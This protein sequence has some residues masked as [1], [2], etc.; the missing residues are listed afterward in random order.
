M[1][2]FSLIAVNYPARN[3]G[4]T[5]YMRGKEAKKVCPELILVS[6]PVTR[7]KSDITRF[8]LRFYIRE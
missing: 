7:G 2:F 6:A 5:R 4:V 3:C 8:K 1:I